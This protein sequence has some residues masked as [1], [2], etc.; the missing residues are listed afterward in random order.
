M[1]SK[2]TEKTGCNFSSVEAALERPELK[3]PSSLS[4][5]SCKLFALANHAAPVAPTMK[6]IDKQE[7][8]ERKKKCGELQLQL[9]SHCNV[10]CGLRLLISLTWLAAA[11]TCFPGAPSDLAVPPATLRAATVELI[12]TIGFGSGL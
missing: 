1:A 11:T 2:K 10:P 4:L 6:Q 3:L 12:A 7:W 8:T 9:Q 5:A